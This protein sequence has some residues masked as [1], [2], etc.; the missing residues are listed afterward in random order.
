MAPCFPTP[1]VGYQ[2]MCSYLVQVSAPVSSPHRV[3]EGPFS[4]GWEVDETPKA[5]LH[6]NHLLSERSDEVAFSRITGRYPQS[7]AAEETE[8]WRNH[9]PKINT[10]GDRAETHET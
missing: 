6:W 9:L 3:F 2:S 8:S 7:M 4:H 5:A 1:L 10:N